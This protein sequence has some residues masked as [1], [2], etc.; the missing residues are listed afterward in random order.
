MECFD[1]K[2]NNVKFESKWIE[3]INKNSK[4]IVIGS[5]YR[6]PHNNFIEFVQYLEGCLGKLAKENKEL[7]LCGDFNFDL[8]KI[9]T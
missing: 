2:I 8:V 5:L 6:H 1:L 3:L 9:D 4:I 7:Y